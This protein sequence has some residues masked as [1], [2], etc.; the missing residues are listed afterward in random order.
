M[1]DQSLSSVLEIVWQHLSRGTADRHH[2]ARHPTLA[3]ISP[4]GP[5]LRTLVL[6]CVDRETSTLEFHTDSASPK[7]AHIAENPAIAIH[8]WIPKAR[9]QIR[10]RGT[11]RLVAGDAKLFDRLPEQAQA[12]YTGPIPGTPLPTDTPN[13]PPRFARLLCVLSE[14]DALI[15][16][17]PH[18]RGLFTSAK[19]WQGAW[20]AP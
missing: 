1:S 5:D 3:T 20:I 6:R 15:L 16:S 4:D 13:T 18:Q 11:A 12:N 8:V 10:A 9:L 7:T 19:D 2:P 14:I 17:D